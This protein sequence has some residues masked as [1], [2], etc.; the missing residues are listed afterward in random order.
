M[1]LAI[2]ICLILSISCAKN[3]HIGTTVSPQCEK[4]KESKNEN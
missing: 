3:L 4:V 1:K 2:M